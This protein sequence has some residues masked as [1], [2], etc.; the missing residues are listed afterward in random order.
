MKLRSEKGRQCSDMLSH[1]RNSSKAFKTLMNSWELSQAR[2]YLAVR[3]VD[4]CGSGGIKCEG[5]L[6]CPLCFGEFC[7]IIIDVEICILLRGS[8]DKI[9]LCSALLQ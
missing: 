8:Y 9:V 7:I 1:V 2:K 4:F 6:E 5:R 3:R